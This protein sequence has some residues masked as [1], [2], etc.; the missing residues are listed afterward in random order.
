MQIKEKVS[1]TMVLCWSEPCLE[2]PVLLAPLLAD[3]PTV[4][5]PPAGG[6]QGHVPHTRHHCA[7]TCRLS[8]YLYYLSTSTL[9]SDIAISWYLHIYRCLSMS[10]LPVSS[11]SLPLSQLSS[12]LRNPSSSEKDRLASPSANTTSWASFRRRTLDIGDIY[13]LG[14]INILSRNIK[15]WWWYAWWFPLNFPLKW[16]RYL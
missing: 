5:V 3:L 10:E 14:F 12:T 11:V 16:Y 1:V 9:P 15:F 2:A 8:R 6:V 4:G 7:A 13:T